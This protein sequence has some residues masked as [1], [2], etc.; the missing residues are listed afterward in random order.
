VLA[1]SHIAPANSGWLRPR[2]LAALAVGAGLAATAIA[3][4]APPLLV[5]VGIAS[6]LVAIVVVSRPLAGLVLIVVFFATVVEV[7][8]LP[9][10]SVGIGRL[11]PIDVI[12]LAYLVMI[13]KRALWPDA[14]QPAISFSLIDLAIVAFMILL[15]LS[16]L[17]GLEQGTTDLDAATQMLRVFGY[18]LTAVVV[19]HLFSRREDLDRLIAAVLILAVAVSMAMIVQLFVGSDI[20]IVNGRVE[21]ITAEG[22]QSSTRIIPGG[23]Y[24]ILV[25][26]WLFTA[27]IGLVRGRRPLQYYVGWALT[28]VAV[29]LTFNRSFFVASALVFAIMAVVSTPW[30]RRKLAGAIGGAGAIAII[31][32]ACVLAGPA[33]QVRDTVVSYLDRIASLGDS[34]TYDAALTDSGWTVSSLEFRRIENEYAAEHLDPP[35]L[36]GLGA[37]ASYRPFDDRLDSEDFPDGDRYI[38]NGHLWVILKAGV[39]GYAALLVAYAATAGW[40]WRV[41]RRARDPRDQAIG[42]VFAL[43]VPSLL[44]ISIV[45]PALA[46]VAWAP[47]FGIIAG[48]TAI[49]ARPLARS[50]GSI[51]SEPLLGEVDD[52]EVHHHRSHVLHDDEVSS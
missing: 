36:L 47:L 21:P 5:A 17:R 42:L 8:V 11:N 48:W 1:G 24:L 43:A 45:D 10:V 40:G 34:D 12:L 2:S 41:W 29:L 27:L 31:V 22:G 46:D 44:T 18:Y 13:A 30:Q 15:L 35:P 20:A 52:H 23:R 6:V 32:V 14:N 16:T 33:N 49:V 50:T 9:L 38:H 7:D 28:S 26:S 37:G 51:R 4:V 3:A 25:G 19:T 39:L